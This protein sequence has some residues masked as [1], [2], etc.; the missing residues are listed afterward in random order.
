MKHLGLLSILLPF[1]G[2]CNAAGA[3]KRDA[4]Y[5]VIAA[6][7]AGTPNLASRKAD[8]SSLLRKVVDTDATTTTTSTMTGATPTTI[9]K[10]VNLTSV[11]VSTSTQAD[12]LQKKSDGDNSLELDGFALLEARDQIVIQ[13]NKPAYATA[14]KQNQD[15]ATACLCYGTKAKVQQTK[16]QIASVTSIVTKTETS[17]T[18]SITTTTSQTTVPCEKDILTDSSNCGRCGRACVNNKYCKGGECVHDE[19]RVATKNACDWGDECPSDS[20]DNGCYG[21]ACFE[22]DLGNG[23]L[24]SD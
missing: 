9:I 12:Q 20:T 5:Q 1:M 16:Y 19:C 10:T 7:G 3:C 2:G 17:T 24:F 11:E 23:C 15:F 13:G 4:C 8:C 18:T 6:G 14:C 21:D 22:I